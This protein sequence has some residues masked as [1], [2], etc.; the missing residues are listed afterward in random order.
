MVSIYYVVVTVIVVIDD[1]AI[2]LREK[3]TRNQKS[4]A[5]LLFWRLPISRH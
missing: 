1:R 5:L 3:R 2:A 4:R